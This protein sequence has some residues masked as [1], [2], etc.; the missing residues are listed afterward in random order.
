MSADQEKHD[1][2]SSSCKRTVS[3]PVPKV[4]TFFVLFF[5]LFFGFNGFEGLVCVF[6][7]LNE[8]MKILVSILFS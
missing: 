8:L 6:Y 4:L 1:D 7:I 2:A 5:C 3:L